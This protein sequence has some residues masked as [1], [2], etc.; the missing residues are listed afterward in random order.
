[1]FSRIFMSILTKFLEKRGLKSPEELDDTPNTD[2]SPTERETFNKWKGILSKETLS[3]EDMKL[4]IQGQIGIIE[5]RWRDMTTSA[6]RKAELIPYHTVY[7][8]LEQAI[9]APRAEREQLEAHL[10]QIIN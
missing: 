7:K 1:M 10:N 6:E 3:L 9:S 2:G 8:T 4:F 5:M